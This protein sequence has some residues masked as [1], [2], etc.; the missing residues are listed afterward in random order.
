MTFEELKQI[1][2]SVGERQGWDFSRM[3]VDCDPMPW[4]YL[5]VAARY[6]R[7]TDRVLDV[8]T[9]GGEK[10]IQLASHFGEGIGIDFDPEMIAAAQRNL[11]RDTPIQFEQMSTDSLSFEDHSFDVVL[12]RQA[13]M[14]ADEIARVL[15]PEGYFITQQIGSSNMRNILMEFGWDLAALPQAK[16]VQTYIDAFESHDCVVVGQA[17][18]DVRYFV[19]DVESLVFWL[20]AIL[21][22]SATGFP[23]TFDIQK[24]WQVID[25]IVSK[26]QTPR[27]IETN[28]HRELLIVQ[29]RSRSF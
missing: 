13:P 16:G 17:T 8:G 27:G 15:K 29:K 19:R 3:Q 25:R 10:F 28:E 4:D 1:A 2:D 26:Y 12:N 11:P 22:Y 9:G 18:Y 23:E 14:A 20:K 5:E 7:P 21:H 6:L 24:H